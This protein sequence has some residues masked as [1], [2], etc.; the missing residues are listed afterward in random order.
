MEPEDLTRLKHVGISRN[1]LLHAHGITTV[2]QLHEMPEAALAAIKSIGDH[3]ARLIKAS[4]AGCREED[5]EPAQAGIPSSREREDGETGREFQEIMKKIRTRLTRVQEALKPLGKRKYV[6]LY[7]D[8][9]KQLKNLNAILDKTDRIQAKLSGKARKKIIKRTAGL[10]E[11]LK[12]AGR[13]PGKRN[14]RRVTRK[15][16]SFAGKLRDVIS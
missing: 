5:R 2:R 15:M 6:P 14:Y 16:L 8:F 11:F 13:K 9:R 12:K 7:V 10:A 3:Y 4:A 1:K